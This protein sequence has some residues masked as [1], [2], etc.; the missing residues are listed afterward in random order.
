MVLRAKAF[1]FTGPL[2]LSAALLCVSQSPLTA[3]STTR[4][5]SATIDDAD[6]GQP[7]SNTQLNV[8]LFPH[9]HEGGCA[10]SESAQPL[11]AFAI[12]TDPNGST[13]PG[14]GYLAK[15]TIPERPPVFGCIFLTRKSIGSPLIG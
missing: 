5:I 7:L 13:A 11:F 2:L 4:T 9:E 6:S 14:G 1:G 15:I 8:Q 12:T 3:A 10:P